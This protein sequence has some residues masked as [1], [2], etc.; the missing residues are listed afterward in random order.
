[1]GCR[2]QVFVDENRR[3]RQ[4]SEQAEMKKRCADDALAM[5]IYFNT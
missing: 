4:G 2:G 1:M 5:H 3:N